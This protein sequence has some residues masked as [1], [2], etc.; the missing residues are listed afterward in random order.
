MGSPESLLYWGSGD[1]ISLNEKLNT[2]IVDLFDELLGLSINND[3]TGNEKR[4]KLR[5]ERD[6]DNI[7]GAYAD[8]R[9][10]AAGS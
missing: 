1:N 9:V 3:L 10:E 7:L 5:I 6:I 8:D 4:I 2:Y